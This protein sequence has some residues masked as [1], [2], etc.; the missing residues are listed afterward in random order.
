MVRRFYPGGLTEKA[1]RW[2]AKTQASSAPQSV[3]GHGEMLLEV[4]LSPQLSAI[5]TP[6]HLIAAD[7][8]PFLPLDITLEIRDAIQG[9]EMD[10]IPNSRHGVVFSHAQQCA[11]SLR[12]FLD[13]TGTK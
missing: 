5:T 10:V 13:R 1:E 6:V 3:L 9:A 8:S 2:F 11:Q 7:N 4:N 12:E